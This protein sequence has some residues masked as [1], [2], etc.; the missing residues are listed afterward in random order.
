[1]QDIILCKV[2]FLDLICVF[3]GFSPF[4]RIKLFLEMF[5]FW[6]VG[7]SF[8]LFDLSKRKHS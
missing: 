3:S 1:M 4:F 8:D 7:N 6:K 5:F 2:S